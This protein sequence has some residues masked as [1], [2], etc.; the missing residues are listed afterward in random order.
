MASQQLWN[1][2]IHYHSLLIEAI[3]HGARQVLDVGC[4]DGILAARLART[5]VPHVIGLDW[6]G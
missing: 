4:G 6:T 3:P 5:G 2:N 1:A